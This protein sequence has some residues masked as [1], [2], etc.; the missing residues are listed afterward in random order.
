MNYQLFVKRSFGSPERDQKDVFLVLC[1]VL[2]DACCFERSVWCFIFCFNDDVNNGIKSKKV[3]KSRKKSK[4]VN[5]KVNGSLRRTFNPLISNQMVNSPKYYR[6]YW[7]SLT[8]N[9]IGNGH[10]ILSYDQAREE[11]F[12]LNEMYSGFIYHWVQ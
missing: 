7:K 2:C 6:I 10:R 9:S 1:Y 12:V 5:K 4:K 8:T 3:E 11:V